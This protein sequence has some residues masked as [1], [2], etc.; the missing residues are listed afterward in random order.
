LL[1]DFIR[2]HKRKIIKEWISF[3]R[4]IASD[5]DEEALRDHAQEIIQALCEDMDK[6]QS[7]R[8][9]T[10]KSKGRGVEHTMRDAGRVHAACFGCGRM[11]ETAIRRASL[12]STRQ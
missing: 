8:E 12:G 2:D 3:A 5:L 10:E 9:E 4:S 6:P 11:Q 1:S 7:A